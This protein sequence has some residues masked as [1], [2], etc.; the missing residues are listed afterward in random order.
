MDRGHDSTS[1]T[2]RRDGPSVSA[3]SVCVT[4]LQTKALGLCTT[5]YLRTDSNICVGSLKDDHQ[6][7]MFGV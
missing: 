2:W 3:G 6:K 1:D 7:R 4:S 5:P